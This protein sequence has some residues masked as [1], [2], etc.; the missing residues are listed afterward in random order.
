LAMINAIMHII[1]AEEAVGTNTFVAA[2]Q[3]L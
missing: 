1:R 3:R 2:H